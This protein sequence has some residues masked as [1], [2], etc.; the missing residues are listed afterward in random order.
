MIAGLMNSLTTRVL[1]YVLVA[2]LAVN[3]Y[4][5]MKGRL[6]T[7][8]AQA[9]TKSETQLT[10]EVRTETRL[11]DG[12]VVVKIEKR[13]RTSTTLTKVKAEGRKAR[14]SISYQRQFERT[15]LSLQPHIDS[16]TLG[17]RFLDTPLWLE[18]GHNLNGPKPIVQVGVRM[19]L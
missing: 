19:E 3:G 15:G 18:A 16:V 11:K 9:P 13:N 5:Y 12:T 8:E 6:Q 17:V 10:E 2:S 7:A 1:A 14:Y 4:L